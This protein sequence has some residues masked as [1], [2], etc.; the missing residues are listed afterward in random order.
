MKKLLLTTLSILMLFSCSGDDDN[1]PDTT[2]QN[3]LVK[4]KFKANGVL[5]Q[6]EGYNDKTGSLP[7]RSGSRYTQSNP[8]GIIELSKYDA[9]GNKLISLDFWIPNNNIGNHILNGINNGNSA[10]GDI[11]N[12]NYTTVQAFGQ[13]QL[14]L[15]ISQIATAAGGLTKGTFS[16]TMKGA[17]VP[18][19]GIV[20]VQ[21][22]EGSFESEK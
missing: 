15:N 21:I 3:V 20:T 6:W 5:Y 13:C 7:L 17:A 18:N 22:T 14:N 8:H 9:N 1:T 2:P 16:G 12:Q 19:G 4:W 11:N 10:V